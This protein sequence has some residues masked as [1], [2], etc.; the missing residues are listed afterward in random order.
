M[1]SSQILDLNKAFTKLSIPTTTKRLEYCLEKSGDDEFFT[2][3]EITVIVR[4]WEDTLASRVLQ[5]NIFA[6]CSSLFVDKDLKN[7]YIFVRARDVSEASL[8]FLKRE[9]VDNGSVALD[10]TITDWGSRQR[11][12]LTK[13]CEMCKSA[14][15]Q[16]HY[17]QE[18]T[19]F[20]SKR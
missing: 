9:I 17:F 12:F 19:R 11:D 1:T 16:Y 4:H 20:V 13:R 5:R 18:R 7:I 8:K 15:D 2:P 3:L 6:V 10:V 14:S